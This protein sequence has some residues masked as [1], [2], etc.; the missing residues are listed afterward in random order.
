[1]KIKF[2]IN[3]DIVSTSNKTAEVQALVLRQNNNNR[4]VYVPKIIDKGDDWSSSISGCIVAQR[5]GINEKWE[6]IPGISLSKLKKDEWTKMELSSAEWLDINEYINK[7]RE[8]CKN[9]NNFFKIQNKQI[10]ILDEHIEK[11]D[12]RKTIEVL[13]N[14]PEK[15]DFIYEL[16]NNKSVINDMLENKEKIKPLLD[17]ITEKN[18]KKLFESINLDLINPKILKDNITNGKEADWQKLF[19]DN[20]YFLSSVI[21][22]ILQII[23]D[24][25]C[26]GAKAINN[27]G[28]S[29]AD[30]VYKNGIDNICIIEIK[31][32]LTKIIE[33]DKYRENVYIPSQ[34]LTSA[35]IQVKEQKDSFMKSYNSIR[36]KSLDNGIEIKAFDP[37]CYLIIGNTES[38]NSKQI[39][40]LNLFRNELRNV[41]IITFDEL[42]SKI[43]IL[44][45]T[46]GGSV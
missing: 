36:L 9:E 31:T 21:P 25:A 17:I 10:L 45:K 6:E 44:Y 2:K 15:S 38:L 37:K 34:E 42:I 14:S 29:I 33:K 3:N 27:T 22:S 11:D 18:K 24:Q 26:M 39:E 30:F 5:K 16:L 23:C 19:K 20:P 41:E 46:L 32:P 8:M 43:E 28:S 7:L 4:I 40:S 1:M 12:I 13:T 35:I